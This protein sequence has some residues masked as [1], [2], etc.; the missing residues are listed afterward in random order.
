MV[1]GL[2]GL[3]IQTADDLA[4]VAG[5]AAEVAHMV[6]AAETAVEAADMCTV[7]AA[8]LFLLPTDLSRASLAAVLDV[9]S[10]SLGSMPS[11]FGM[12]TLEVSRCSSSMLLLSSISIV[13]K[14]V[15]SSERRHHRFLFLLS[16]SISPPLSSQKVDHNQTLFCIV[17]THPTCRT[18]MICLIETWTAS[19]SRI[20]MEAK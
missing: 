13:L 1:A 14:L 5:M 10:H 17:S 12:L 18:A 15:P 16:A 7:P 20:E 3:H 4:A 2:A 11:C 9:L 8:D 19:R 6:N